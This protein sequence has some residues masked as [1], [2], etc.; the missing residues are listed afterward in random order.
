MKDMTHTLNSEDM[1]WSWLNSSMLGGGMPV[2]TEGG[3]FSEGTLF[4][5]KGFGLWDSEGFELDCL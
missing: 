5:K 1:N 4:D 3:G 2:V